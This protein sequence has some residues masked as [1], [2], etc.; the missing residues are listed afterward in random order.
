MVYNLIEIEIYDSLLPM[1]SSR[2]IIF[3]M[4]VPKNVELYNSFSLEHL[5]VLFERIRHEMH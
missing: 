3:L 2:L 4:A 1:V 5:N